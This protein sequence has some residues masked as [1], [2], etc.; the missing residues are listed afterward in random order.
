MGMMDSITSL[1]NRVIITTNEERVSNQMA[2]QI[3]EWMS[4]RQGLE[5]H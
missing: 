2:L 5:T 3:W 4:L 1:N